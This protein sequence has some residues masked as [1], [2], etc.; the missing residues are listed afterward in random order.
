MWSPWKNQLPEFLASVILKTIVPVSWGLF[1]AQQKP[2]TG[3][4]PDILETGMHPE[5]GFSSV[6]AYVLGFEN[7]C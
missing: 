3:G 5:T 1:F 4:S 2:E 7:S 6:R